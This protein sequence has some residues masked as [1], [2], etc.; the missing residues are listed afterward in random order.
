[1]GKETVAGRGKMKGL[2]SVGRVGLLFNECNPGAVSGPRRAEAAAAAK[3]PEVLPHRGT[4]KCK[5]LRRWE[6]I[7]FHKI[8]IICST[9]QRPFL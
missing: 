1:M 5:E 3:S 2:R 4:R 9:T 8:G 6:W 7:C